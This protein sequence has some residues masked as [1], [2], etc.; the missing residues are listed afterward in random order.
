[1]RLVLAGLVMLGLPVLASAQASTERR[2]SSSTLPPIGLPL[3]AIGLPLPAIGL[4]PL[5]S[6][7]V[8][9]T[10]RVDSTEQPAGRRGH[11]DGPKRRGHSS[12]SIVV[13]GAPYLWYDSAV[14]PTLAGPAEI[15]ATVALPMGRLRLELQPGGEA[16]QVFVD[17]AYV[18][19]LA[20]VGGALELEAGTRRIEIRATGYEPLVFDARIVAGQA[21]GYRGALEPLPRDTAPTEPASRDSVPTAEPPAPRPKQTFYFI[22]GCYLGNIP[23]DQV[24]LPPGCDLTR[25]ITRTP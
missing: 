23:P 20:D 15:E 12:P 18:G 3:P 22:P 1:M 6:P 5:A 7:S 25:L 16:V 4:P 11:R 19:T 21:I 24:R 10:R 13:F 9:D 17:G 2:P 14:T 8:E